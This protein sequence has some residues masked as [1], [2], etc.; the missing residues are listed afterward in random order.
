MAPVVPHEATD[1][2]PIFVHPMTVQF[3]EADPAGISFFANAYVYAHRAYEAF[4][5]AHGPKEFFKAADYI[6]PFVHTECDHKAPMY[7]GE[8]LR[9]EVHLRKLGASSMT[10][11]YRIRGG[12]PDSLRAVVTMVSVFVD[13]KSFKP[14]PIPDAVRETLR[15]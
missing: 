6:V 12:E 3:D 1:G 5:R 2:A 8:Q 15:P 13:A 11:E 10:F 7:P 4:M 14:I 9:V